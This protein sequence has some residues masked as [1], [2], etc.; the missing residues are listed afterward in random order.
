V[1]TESCRAWR[2]RLASS[3]LGRIDADEEVA[4]RAHLD[5]CASCRAE[6]AELG[7]VVALLP[8]ADVTR[9]IEVPSPPSDLGERVV[10]LVADEAAR[11]RRRRRGR[12]AAGLAVAAAF[13]LGASV[14][15]TG[16]GGVDLT[17]EAPAGVTASA[18]LAERAWGT[19]IELDVAG[20]PAGETY[21]VWLE[22]PDG[23]RTPAGTFVAV[24]ER[25]MHLV[26]AAGLPLDGAS[27]LGISTTDDGETVLFSH[28][29]PG[30]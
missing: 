25:E 7:A 24:A 20:L 12:A 18:T 17:F 14:L 1:T 28:I 21:G 9:L 29:P 13:V 26:L 15:A 19:Q 2:E 3:L 5:G 23:S 8:L 6:A 10:S 16:D 11:S 30:D 22:R 4:L 27:G